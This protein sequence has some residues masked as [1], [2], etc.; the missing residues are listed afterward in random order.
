MSRRGGARDCSLPTR[1]QQR[2]LPGYVDRHPSPREK[3]EVLYHEDM[4]LKGCD[5]ICQVIRPPNVK[6]AQAEVDEDPCTRKNL[7]SILVT[8]Q[9]RL[10]ALHSLIWVPCIGR[11]NSSGYINEPS[12]LCDIS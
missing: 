4:P 1:H 6:H 7:N 9:Q 8:P 2:A 3:V 12:R 10:L 11:N 5:M